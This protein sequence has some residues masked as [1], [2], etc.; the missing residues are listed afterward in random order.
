MSNIKN[1]RHGEIGMHL[2]IE[3]KWM[4]RY[5]RLKV[6]PL[7]MFWHQDPAFISISGS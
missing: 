6:G 5:R 3:Q 1:V 7:E 2:E 4:E